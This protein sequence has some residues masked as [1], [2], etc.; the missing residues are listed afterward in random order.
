MKID[1]SI[2]GPN[3][4]IFFKIIEKL[5]KKLILEKV[6][7]SGP[8]Y[9][10]IKKLKIATRKSPCGEG[11][12]TWDHWIMKIYKVLFRIF[13]IKKPLGELIKKLEIPEGIKIK[14]KIR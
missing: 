7:F 13:I 8:I 14:I 10:P 9:F 5:K 4:E 2:I 6:V 11:S 3:K 12:E 1:V